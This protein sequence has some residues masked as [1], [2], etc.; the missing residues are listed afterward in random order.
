[1]IKGQIFQFHLRKGL[2]HSSAQ[3]TENDPPGCLSLLTEFEHIHFISL[4]WP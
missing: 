4:N 1:M 3:R 2:A